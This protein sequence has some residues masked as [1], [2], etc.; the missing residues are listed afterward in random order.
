MKDS[1]QLT[2]TR[3][4]DLGYEQLL[5]LEGKPGTRVKVVFRGVLLS[6]DTDPR[7]YVLRRDQDPAPRAKPESVT[8]VLGAARVGITAPIH[9]GWLQRVR[10]AVLA[11]LLMTVARTSDVNP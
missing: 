7:N 11:R 4:V 3:T 8:V 10:D 5:I 6:S 2:A 9:S 1:W